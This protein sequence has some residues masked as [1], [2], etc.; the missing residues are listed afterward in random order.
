MH[1]PAC[2]AYRVGDAV[3]VGDILFMPGVVTARCDF[4]V[5][6]AHTLYRSVRKLLSLPPEARLFMCHDYPPGDRAPVWESPVADPRAGNIHLCD[7]ARENDFV[8]LRTQQDAT[9]KIPPGFERHD[10]AAGLQNLER[11]GHLRMPA[12]RFTGPFPRVASVCP[13]SAC[14]PP[15]RHFRSCRSAS[16]EPARYRRTQGYCAQAT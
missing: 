13:A 7:G 3:F 5:G 9:L 8:S 14:R 6:N 12:A 15:R 11:A 4:P 16:H 10:C 1:A 2:M